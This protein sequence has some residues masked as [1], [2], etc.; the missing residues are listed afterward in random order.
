MA[1]GPL[2]PFVG[3]LIQGVGPPTRESTTWDIHED[4]QRVCDFH[5]RP[6][7]RKQAV[8]RLASVDEELR[9][10]LGID[11]GRDTKLLHTRVSETGRVDMALKRFSVP[12]AQIEADLKEALHR[13]SQGTGVPQEQYH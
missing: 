3:Y 6:D 4:R 1:L 7:I 2:N 10:F 9:Y 8:L 5:R 13:E 11:R 12:A